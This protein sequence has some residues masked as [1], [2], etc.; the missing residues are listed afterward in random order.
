MSF[1]S[2]RSP[3]WCIDYLISVCVCC[4]FS[5]EICRHSGNVV[6]CP[7]L[8]LCITGQEMLTAQTD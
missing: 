5:L 6:V 1:P 7:P 2:D 3:S 4:V 8:F